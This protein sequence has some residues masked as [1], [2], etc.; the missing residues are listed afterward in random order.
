MGIGELYILG[1]GLA[2]N[3]LCVCMGGGGVE[4]F[5]ITSPFGLK[6]PICNNTRDTFIVLS[7]GPFSFGMKDSGILYVIDISV[8]DQSPSYSGSSY[9]RQLLLS[10]LG[11]SFFSS[12]FLPYCG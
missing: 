6:P 10:E 12:L 1:E 3:N 4:V 11:L 8:I 9:P 7:T 5:K 2:D